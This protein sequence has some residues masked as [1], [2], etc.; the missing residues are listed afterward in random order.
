MELRLQSVIL[1][2]HADRQFSSK[3]QTIN[4]K[5][6]CF[7]SIFLLFPKILLT[8]Q[9]LICCQ[10]FQ[11]LCIRW[12]RHQ[13]WTKKWKVLFRIYWSSGVSPLPGILFFCVNSLRHPAPGTQPEEKMLNSE[14]LIYFWEHG[15]MKQRVRKKCLRDSWQDPFS[16]LLSLP[17]GSVSAVKLHMRV[18]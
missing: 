10:I 16:P 6:E 14:D 13:M 5:T 18:I 9:K 4:S 12:K 7:R 8:P 17:R 1:P 2:D 11:S 3:P 15:K